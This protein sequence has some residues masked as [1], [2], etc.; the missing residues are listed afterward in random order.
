MTFFY[1][2]DTILPEVITMPKAKFTDIYQSLKQNILDGLYD[3]NR[4]LPTEQQL[5]LIFSCSRNTIRR[6]IAQLQNEGFVQSIK[7]KGVVLLEHNAAATFQ[8]DLHNF[9]GLSSIQMDQSVTTATSVL[10][11]QTL[12]IDEALALKTGFPKG[13]EV[14]YLHRL[15]YFDNEPLVLDINYFLK[16]VIKD[17]SVDIAQNSIYEY[18]EHSLKLHV[19]ACH[20]MIRVEKATEQDSDLLRLNDYNCVGVTL[21]NAYLDDGKMFE[22]TESRHAPDHFTFCETVSLK[23]RS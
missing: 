10:K 6:A 1:F 18:I 2:H 19:I 15:R 9:K 14:Y 13:T 22:F 17:L 11:F 16:D 21:N 5:T 7:G 8:I 23:D 4:M 3:E 20:R 12:M